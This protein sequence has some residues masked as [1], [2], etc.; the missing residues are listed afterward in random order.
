[1]LCYG[2]YQKKKKRQK[3]QETISMLATH[4]QLI[5]SYFLALKYL[6][7]CSLPHFSV[8]IIY[9]FFFL[10]EEKFN[11]IKVVFSPPLHLPLS[12]LMVD[13]KNE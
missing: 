12:N 7:P 10:L 11:Q 13:W 9:S 5:S 2:R 1:M 3:R 4:A 8:T 6:L